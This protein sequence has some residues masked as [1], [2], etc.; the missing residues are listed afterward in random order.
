MGNRARM[1]SL[2]QE[3]RSLGYK[4]HFAGV[5]LSRDERESTAPHV[6]EW[7]CDFPSYYKTHSLSGRIRNAIAWRAHL[8]ASSISVP[9]FVDKMFLPPWLRQ[10]R[11]LQRGRGYQRILVSY[12][13]YSRFLQAFPEAKVRIIDTHDV[14]SHRR[15]HLALAGISDYWR[16]LTPEQEAYGLRRATRIIAIQE[17]EATLLRRLPGVPPVFTVGHFQHINPQPFPDDSSPTIGF[18]GSENSTNRHAVSWF[19][20]HAWPRVLDRVPNSSLLIAGRIGDHVALAPGVR[21]L[22]QLSDL[23]LFYRQCHLV[24][25]P[26]QAGTGLKIKTV[27]ALAHGRC[28]LSTRSGA[29]GLPTEKHGSLIICESA[30]DFIDHAIELLSNPGCARS[31]GG[32]GPEYIERLNQRHRQALAAVLE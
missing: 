4:V 18:V 29:E 30:R 27:E 6:D 22:G 15:E 13:Q 16:T 10:A 1:Q 12:V 24:I 9:R 14:F 28:V 20:E 23:A 11:E 17:C 2:I 26:I 31:R 19:L 7:V 3:S 21:I 32:S 25:N 8:L 5:A